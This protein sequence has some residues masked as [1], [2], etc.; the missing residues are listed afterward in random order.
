MK[1]FILLALFALIFMEGVAWY[2]LKPSQ[3]SEP[4]AEEAGKGL[5]KRPLESAQ[6]PEEPNA[7]PA[8]DVVEGLP[9]VTVE[10][11]GGRIERTI[12]MGVRQW[13][14][15]PATLSVKQGELVRLVIHNAD[16]V[17]HP[18]FIPDLGI[19]A[20][21]PPEGA[22]VEFT[23]EKKGRFP[24]LCGQYCGEGHAQMQIGYTLI[25]E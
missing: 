7:A 16:T 21:V 10:E 1:R 22:V 18:L 2:A 9:P 17:H 11:K 12:H 19:E 20:D 13:T 15:E 24:F 8:S 14:W 5:D 25:V 23:A 3:T 4:Q 6:V